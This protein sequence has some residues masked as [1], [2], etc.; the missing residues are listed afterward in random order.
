[1]GKKFL[2]IF[3][4]LA[5]ILLAAI[6]TV[7][8]IDATK[9]AEATRKALLYEEET[10]AFR[11][12]KAE[13]INRYGEV[14]DEVIGDAA[15]FK[16][17]LSMIFLGTSSA[18]Y[19]EL[20]PVMFSTEPEKNM[21][22]VI[23]LSPGELPGLEDRISMGQYYE[24]ISDGGWSTA[25]YWEGC[26]EKRDDNNQLI[27]TVAALRAYLDM[28]TALLSERGLDFPETIVFK[29]N[30]TYDYKLMDP[31]LAEYGI[32]YAVHNSEGKLALIEHDTEEELGVLHPGAI[33]W[34]VQMLNGAVYGKN[35]FVEDLINLGGCSAFTVSFFPRAHSSYSDAHYYGSTVVENISFTKMIE[36][37]RGRMNDGN[38]TVCGVEQGFRNRIMYLGKFA[39]FA[40]EIAEIR[41]ELE[42][43]MAVLDAKIKEVADK[44]YNE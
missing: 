3:L 35:I 20:Y 7:N 4:S 26:D 9:R 15:I 44:Y 2:A 42:Q 24:M 27:D 28:M 10:R 29:N 34:Q 22:G 30:N 43:Q 16:A 31:V 25:I 8:A 21:T 18:L 17:N 39:E 36:Y 40:D 19:D 1:M 32:E 37:I 41:A 14:E 12:E 23:C 5:L 38:L 33:G 6:V 11:M 13:L